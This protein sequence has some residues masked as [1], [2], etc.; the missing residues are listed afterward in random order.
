MSNSFSLQ[1]KKNT[2]RNYRGFSNFEMDCDQDIIVLIGENGAGKSS[3]TDALAVFLEGLKDKITGKKRVTPQVSDNDI[4]VKQKIME[5]ELE[6]ECSYPRKVNA[7]NE[8]YY[9]DVPLHPKIT[10]KYPQGQ[11]KRKFEIDESFK[12][13]LQYVELYREEEESWNYPVIAYYGVEEL[14][15]HEA[16]HYEVSSRFDNIYKNALNPE[17]Y[18]FGNFKNWFAK[19][20]FDVMYFKAKAFDGER[21]KSKEQHIAASRSI[22]DKVIASILGMLNNAGE[23]FQQSS[24]QEEKV[25]KDISLDYRQ[26]KTRLVLHKIV[27]GEEQKL[28]MSQLSDGEQSIIALVGDLARRMIAA[29][30]NPEANKDWLEGQGIVLIDEIDLHLHPKWQQTIIP[31]LRKTF[32]GIQFIITSHSPY[33]V[34]ALKEENLKGLINEQG[35][36]RLV[37][38]SMQPYGKRIEEILLEIF[39]VKGLRNP[40]VEAKLARLETM[41]EREEYNT[42]DFKQQ[43]QALEQEIGYAD[44]DLALIRLETKR[45]QYE[46]DN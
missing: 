40:E 31:F 29:N 8:K 5:C 34:S 38:G 14:N 25:Y 21:D 35:S 7:N 24:N 28:F 17:K 43:L 9:E 39:D 30:P 37:E 36:I 3:L 46:A 41:L 13:F 2:L 44:R 15:L 1:L 4:T 18:S 26:G 42:D 10:Y 27:K 19:L 11:Q 45:K 16:K 22:L 32:P 12:E 6:L 20:Y 33:I 23:D